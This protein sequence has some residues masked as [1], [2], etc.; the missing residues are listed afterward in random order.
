MLDRAIDGDRHPSC[1]QSAVGRY[2]GLEIACTLLSAVSDY[3]PVILLQSLIIA[4]ENA[5]MSADSCFGLFHLI[6]SVSTKRLLI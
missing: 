5:S 1:C 6:L 3:D 4:L 2:D